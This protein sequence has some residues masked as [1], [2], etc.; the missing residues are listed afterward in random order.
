M[1]TT[2]IYL[3]TNI[4]N[5]PN[6][7]YIGKTINYNSRKYDHLKK[8]GQNIKINIIDEVNSH[9]SKD[10]K[11]LECFWIEQFKVW[12]FNICNK[13]NGGG[14][15]EFRTQNSIKNIRQKLQKP[16]IQYDLKGNIVKEFNSIKEAKN[17][18]G[19][20]IDRCL[21]HK[22]KTAGGYFWGYK[23][24]NNPQFDFSLRKGK[25]VNQYN[26]KGELI[27]TFNSTQEAEKLFNN[28]T[29]D[30][31]GACCRN[32]QKTAYGFIWKYN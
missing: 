24:E 28:S 13:N 11:P 27:N 6:K 16:I 26:L 10:W 17:Q 22:G 1:R 3:I 21:K 5:D 31:I 4:N 29:K 30:N 8:Y 9:Y 18:F 19:S 20:F 2:Y 7:I 15:V 25:E 14:G 32:K 12:G 23:G